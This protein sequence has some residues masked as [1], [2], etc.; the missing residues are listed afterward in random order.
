M[1]ATRFL[2]LSDIHFSGK[3]KNVGFD[4]DQDV[5]NEVVR[6]IRS[7]VAEIGQVDAVLVSGDIGYSGKKS[8]YDDAAAWLDQVC[9]AGGCSTSSVY[10]CPGNH[11]VDRSV[12]LANG[13]IQDMHDA[14]RGKP[15]WHEQEAHLLR[16][17]QEPAA[18]R[19]LYEPLQEFNEFAARYECSFYSDAYAWDKDF[20]LNDGSILRLRGMNSALLSGPSDAAGTLCLTSRAWTLQRHE[21]VEYM[22]M[23]H[24]PPSWLMDGNDAQ[25]S[26]DAKSKIQLFGHEHDQRLLPG[27]DFVRLF[28]GSVNPHRPEPNWRPGYNFID[29]SVENSEGQRH[30]IVAVRQREWSRQPFQFRSLQNLHGDDVDVSRIRLDPWNASPTWETP[31]SP[32]EEKVMTS[33]QSEPNGR[34]LRDVINQFFRLTTSQKNSIAGQLGL[35]DDSDRGLPDFERY[36][37]A[38]TRAREESKWE[39]LEEMVQKMERES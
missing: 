32:D 26:F 20:P 16:R 31:P 10:V 34:P 5:R 17:L 11:D 29:V 24:H 1:A 12:L 33:A 15:S 9:A 6:D 4:P 23:S 30:M 2:H 38:L 3:H 14:V 8:E 25:S 36:K 19:L 28:A 13:T 39:K 35:S 21:G 22:V 18:S 27:R 37:R 7:Q